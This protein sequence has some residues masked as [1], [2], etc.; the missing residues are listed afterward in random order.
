MEENENSKKSFSKELI[1]GLIIGL[2]IGLGVM[3]VINNTGKTVAKIGLKS[4]T[5]ADMY[6]AME[7]YYSSDIALQEI[8]KVILKGKYKLNEEELDEVKKAADNYISQYEQYGYTKEDFLS[9]NG[10]KNYDE[11]VDMLSIDYK[12]TIY[13]YDFLEKKLEED[14]VKKYYDE[15]AFGK[16]NTKHILVKTSDTIT[17]EQALNV[18]N[19]IIGKLNEG[20]EFDSLAE[21]Y[22]TENE[23]IITEDLGEKGAF[24]NL[25]SSYVDAM[26]ELEKGKYTVTPVKTSY[27]YHVIYCVDKTEKTDKISRKDRM[28]IVYELAQDIIAED[29]DLY[30]KALISMREEA[31]VKF[32]NKR[33]KEQYETYCNQ[34]AEV[35]E[36]NNEG[37]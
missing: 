12:R 6:K 26:K 5:T 33:L 4:I 18:A 30:S 13:Y 19:E 15:N 22:S 31:K 35:E 14:A 28:A 29:S 9:E 32:K 23:N 25:E 10:F 3:Y 2:V 24:D 36:E 27:G 34:Y 20:E 17:D 7:N 11:F 21:K 16:V 1:I 8:D 37:E